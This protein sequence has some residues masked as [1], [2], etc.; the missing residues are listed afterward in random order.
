M[1]LGVV[2]GGRV[3]VVVVVVVGSGVICLQSKMSKRLMPSSSKSAITLPVW[4]LQNTST[5]ALPS[6]SSSMQRR[7]IASCAPGVPN[8]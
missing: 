8:G 5:E 3:V 4:F 6:P 7:L 2:V 1:V